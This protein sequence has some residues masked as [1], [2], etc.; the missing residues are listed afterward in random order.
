MS[1]FD[2]VTLEFDVDFYTMCQE[3]GKD[4]G[5]EPNFIIN[6][7]FPPCVVTVTSAFGNVSITLGRIVFLAGG[8]HHVFPF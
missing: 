4:D 7:A 3:Y 2:V 1:A 5:S 8:S 6:I